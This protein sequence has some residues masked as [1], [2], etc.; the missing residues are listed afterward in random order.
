MVVNTHL[1]WNHQHD[2][3]KAAQ[4]VH[5]LEKCATYYKAKSRVGQQSELAFVLG[6]D[7]NAK[8]VSSVMSILLNESLT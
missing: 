6:G 3:V 7:F 5:L 2:Y 1:Y 4:A 8:P